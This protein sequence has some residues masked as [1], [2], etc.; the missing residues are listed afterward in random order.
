[1]IAKPITPSEFEIRERARTAANLP[2]ACQP[3][4]IPLPATL[5]AP[6]L[7]ALDLARQAGM[8]LG[9][10]SRAESIVLFH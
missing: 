7:Q 5:S 2:L 4:G 8:T 3:G 9:T 1:L 10:M 6:T